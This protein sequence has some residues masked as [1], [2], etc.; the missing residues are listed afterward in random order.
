MVQV[1]RSFLALYLVC[2]CCCFGF[3][4]YSSFLAKCVVLRSLTIGGYYAVDGLVLTCLAGLLAASL[5]ALYVRRR[6]VTGFI[7][8]Y[9]LGFLHALMCALG[10]CY[11]DGTSP[12]YLH[13]LQTG[14]SIVVGW[15]TLS[16]QLPVLLLLLLLCVFE[17]FENQ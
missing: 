6:D 1:A 13:P 3:V 16:L 12:V 4:K 7:R 14:D 5:V 8:V 15:T 17:R 9:Q 10:R 2:N 11:R